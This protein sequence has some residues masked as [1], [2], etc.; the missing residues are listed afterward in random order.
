MKTN[1]EMLSDSFDRR[2]ITDKDLKIKMLYRVFQSGN[3]IEHAL[4]LKRINTCNFIIR[5][6]NPLRIIARK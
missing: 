5:S 1:L 2:T 6:D 3:L 4:L